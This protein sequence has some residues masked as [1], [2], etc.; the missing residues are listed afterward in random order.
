MLQTSRKY[1]TDRAAGGSS[2][3]EDAIHSANTHNNLQTCFVLLCSYRPEPFTDLCIFPQ[4]KEGRGR[5][6]KGEGNRPLSFEPSS[7]Y[8]PRSIS[9]GS[10]PLV[11]RHP[12]SHLHPPS[13]SILLPGPTGTSA[14]LI[15]HPPPETCPN[16]CSFPISSSPASQ[17]VATDITCPPG[18][19]S[20]LALGGT[21]QGRGSLLRREIAS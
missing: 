13:L 10:Q 18:R 9:L 19:G 11:L 6:R 5:V 2:S 20:I 17:Q 1:L 14:A 7:H 12:A 21:H 8:A 3:L 15:R 16:S 4:Q